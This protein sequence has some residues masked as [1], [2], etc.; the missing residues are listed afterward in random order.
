MDVNEVLKKIGERQREISALTD[1]DRNLSFD[2]G[3][4]TAWDPEPITLPKAGE[5]REEYFSQLARNNVQAVLNKLY[6]LN[7]TEIVDGERVL[8]LPEPSTV[9]PRGKPVPTP[10]PPTKWEKF[11]REKGIKSNKKR[12]K[13][14]WD[15]VTRKYV[16]RYGFKKVQNEKEK[17]WCVEVPD[18]Q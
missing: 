18:N 13:L 15:D 12:D 9:L 10:K 8:K 3:N 11:A 1:V 17:N 5:Q 4:L 6:S 16:P 14:V 7:E 2:I